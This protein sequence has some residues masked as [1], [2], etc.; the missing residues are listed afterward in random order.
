MVGA[1][2]DYFCSLYLFRT[3][4][5]DIAVESAIQKPVFLSV[6]N[7]TVGLKKDFRNKL[8]NLGPLKWKEQTKVMNRMHPCIAQIPRKHMKGK[9]EH[10]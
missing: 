5:N 7:R 3:D 9:M 6:T 1:L 4:K 2:H 10:E 8:S